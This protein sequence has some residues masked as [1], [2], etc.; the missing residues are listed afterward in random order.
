MGPPDTDT[1]AERM[2][3]QFGHRE[4]LY[5]ALLADMADDWD[6]GGVT[7]EIFGEWPD[8]RSAWRDADARQF[9]QLSLLAGVFRLV[10]RG[11]APHLVGWYPCLGGDFD[12][13][14]AWASFRPVLAAHV[15]EL[16][17][18]LDIAP[19]T[20]EPGRTVALLVGI[21]D[22][23]RRTGLRRIRLLEPGASGGL[24][25][26][27]DRYRYSGDGWSAGPADATTHLT[28]CGA[29]GFVPESFSVVERRGCDVAP[30]DATTE[31]GGQYLRSFVWPW[32]IERHSRLAAALAV[33]RRAR[34]PSGGP[35]VVVD[36]ASAADWLTRRLAEPVDDGVLTVVWHSVT[37]LYWPAKEIAAVTAAIDDARARMPLA[38]LALEHSWDAVG[39]VGDPGLPRLEVDGE[40]VAVCDHHGPPVRVLW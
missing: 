6:D 31:A 32:M 40:P 10:L 2:R 39:A 15:D 29:A 25:L 37:R 36:R 19:Q 24:G 20:N 34:T 4:H 35:A 1:L 5:G 3:R 38:H 18:S 23:V 21:A 22:A 28:G 13:G 8:P 17:S 7:R 11:E 30:V 9:P 14:E 26:L 33:A 16:R 27:V 12:P